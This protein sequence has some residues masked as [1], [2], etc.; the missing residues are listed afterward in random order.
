MSLYNGADIAHLSLV[1]NIV[2]KCLQDSGYP[3]YIKTSDLALKLK[4]EYYW[5]ASI[6]ASG[7]N[8]DAPEGS[9][10]KR[11]T[12][13]GFT[14]I[15]GKS[16]IPG[17][18]THGYRVQS[19]P[20]KSINILLHRD[21]NKTMQDKVDIAPSYPL[22]V[23]IMH[24]RFLNNLPYLAFKM[25]DIRD[26][27]SF[28]INLNNET[29]LSFDEQLIRHFTVMGIRMIPLIFLA[30]RIDNVNL[31]FQCAEQ[32][33]F[34]ALNIY[35]VWSQHQLEKEHDNSSWRLKYV[36]PPVIHDDFHILLSEAELGDEYMYPIVRTNIKS[37]GYYTQRYIHNRVIYA[38]P[39]KK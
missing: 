23:P 7:T 14:Y 33:A 27:D 9:N 5:V 29:W 6:I 30:K 15:M 19:L 22:I 21:P 38:Q 26:I 24:P 1:D 32:N 37:S 3:I 16:D 18:F 20:E 12:I 2:P 39:I 34:G 25:L 10:A 31:K 17:T 36:Y 4:G 35:P 8:W 11:F 13:D 28:Q